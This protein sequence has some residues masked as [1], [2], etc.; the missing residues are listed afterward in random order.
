MIQYFQ[1]YAI[2]NIL[3]LQFG[4]AFLR[5]K[6]YNEPKIK[7]IL[8]DFLYKIT[9][10]TLSLN[11]IKQKKY[12]KTRKNTIYFRNLI[13]YKLTYFYQQKYSLL[14][15]KM[16]SIITKQVALNNHYYTITEIS[17]QITNRINRFILLLS[18]LLMHQILLILR[19]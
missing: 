13:T 14:K 2:C 18:M 12:T 8:L 15:L 6:Y 7:D 4:L 16:L 17:Y 5:I 19:R 9:K 10:Q 11:Q 1:I 3:D